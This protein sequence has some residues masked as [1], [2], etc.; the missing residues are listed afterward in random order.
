M[1]RARRRRY[2]PRF[3]G[4]RTPSYGRRRYPFGSRGIDI[5]SREPVPRRWCTE[6]RDKS[7][8]RKNSWSSLLK[9]DRGLVTAVR[10]PLSRHEPRWTARKHMESFPHIAFLSCARVQAGEVAQDLLLAA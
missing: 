6:W 1:P 9:A 3:A 4:T 2:R 5:E 8:R 7:S 10:V